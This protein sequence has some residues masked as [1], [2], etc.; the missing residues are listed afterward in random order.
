MAILVE[1]L[2]TYGG[3]EVFARRL[4]QALAERGH[5][6]DVLCARAETDPPPGVGVVTLGRPPLGKAIKAAWFA[7][8]AERARKRGRY[9]V[10][11]SCG[12]TLTQDIARVSGG[13]LR[14]F[15]EKSIRAYPY[16][17]ARL[18]K[19]LRRALSP[20]N[21]VG[22]AIQ[23]RQFAVPGR[24]VCVSHL[25][26]DWMAE[27]FPHLAEHGMDVVYNQPDLTRFRPPSQAEREA[28]RASFGIATG[29]AV[30]SLAGTNFMLKGVATAVAAM[31][32]LPSHIRLLVAG[33]RNPAR[34]AAQAARLGVGNRVIFLGRVTD[35]PRLYHA[36]DV[37][38]LPTFYDTCANVV[39][40]A[41]ASGAK[42]ITTR[43]NGASFFLPAHCVLDD[44]A[45]SHRLATLI[46]QALSE[47]A[48]TP[49]VW[50]DDVACGIE[51]YVALVDEILTTKRASSRKESR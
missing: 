49:F 8:T 2:A 37:F 42:A 16:G 14:V 35:M 30:V 10:A 39:L 27:T 15:Q 46:K 43:D 38:V 12:N 5:E 9:D 31:A 45:D 28:A 41:L 51:P 24:V 4:A 47:P 34:F 29:E 22:R 48:P 11:I 25:V 20:A 36:S 17:L 13:P 6:V 19:R 40:E 33:G 3:T 21:A 32:E 18:T 1:R 44:P 26:R 7:I 50:P 23:Q